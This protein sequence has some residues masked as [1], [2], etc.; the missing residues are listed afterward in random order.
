MNSAANPRFWAAYRALP[1]D[2]QRRARKAYA[3]WR[4][5]PFH[6]SL[7]FKKVG[8]LWSA[9]IGTDYRALADVRGD[10]AYWVWI[11]SHAD[12]DHLLA[13]HRRKR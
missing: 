2:V 10:T 3:L 6:P 12:Y 1:A 7:H 9:R 4:A 5:D 8:R 13:A 11:G